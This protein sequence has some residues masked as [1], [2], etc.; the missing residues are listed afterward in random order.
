MWCIAHVDIDTGRPCAMMIKDW[1]KLYNTFANNF[2][3]PK[4]R[5]TSKHSYSIPIGP[6]D[7]WRAHC[8]SIQSAVWQVRRDEITDSVLSNKPT[9]VACTDH[10]LIT[11][12]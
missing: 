9:S 10:P 11:N 6:I 12:Q 8:T 1:V 2:N 4:D 5:C 3:F 7:E